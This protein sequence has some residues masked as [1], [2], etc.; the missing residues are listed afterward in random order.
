MAARTARKPVDAAK[1]TAPAAFDLSTRRMAESVTFSLRDPVDPRVTLDAT[2]TV[3]SPR[4]KR[5]Q[6]AAARKPIT[7][8]DD[9]KVSISDDQ[10]AESLLERA[11][12]ATVAWTNI[13]ENGEPLPC[14][15]ATVRRVFTDPGTAWVGDQVQGQLLRLAD[16]FGARPSS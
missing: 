1:G 14:D 7:I 5:V 2:I 16:F 9:G 6:A 3:L 11:V 13:T 12:A 8:A 4:S 10:F 15:E